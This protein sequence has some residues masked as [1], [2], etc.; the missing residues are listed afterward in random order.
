MTPVAANPIHLDSTADN[1]AGDLGRKYKAQEESAALTVHAAHERTERMIATAQARW[2]RIVEAIKSLVAGYN[3]GAGHEVLKVVEERPAP[4]GPVVRIGSGGEE[5]P[6]LSATLEGLLI[7]VCTRDG[8][9]VLERTECSLRPD[10]SDDRTA[11]YLIQNW[12][13][14]IQPG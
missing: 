12:L 10:R 7:C 13:T 14:R 11:A 1:W 5:G 9:G 2:V 4:D 3:A 6:F 8:Q